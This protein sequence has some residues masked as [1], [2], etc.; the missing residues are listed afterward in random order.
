MGKAACTNSVYNAWEARLARPRGLQRGSSLPGLQV[1][2][3]ESR[4]SGKSSR[5][6]A[7]GPTCPVEAAQPARWWQTSCLMEAAHHVRPSGESGSQGCAR[8]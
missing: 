1:A 4:G 3:Q 6:L 5:G 2:S 7:G 8:L